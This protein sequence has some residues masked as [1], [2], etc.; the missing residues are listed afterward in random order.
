MVPGVLYRVIDRN[1]VDQG[2]VSMFSIN[3]IAYTNIRDMRAV[4]SRKRV[5]QHIRVNLGVEYVILEAIGS[6]VPSIPTSLDH[7]SYNIAS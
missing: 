6:N 2:S 3:K 7:Q 5:T 1:K 4:F